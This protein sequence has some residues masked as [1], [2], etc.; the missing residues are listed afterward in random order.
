MFSDK[1]ALVFDVNW[2]FEAIDDFI[3]NLLP[4]PFEYA[5]ANVSRSKSKAPADKAKPI[6]VLLSKERRRLAVVPGVTKPTG[7][8]LERFKGRDKAS[9]KDSHI[10]IGD[11]PIV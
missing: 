6:W 4:R 10:F 1:K 5:D 2:Q 9:I 11:C 3:R 7:K 8:D